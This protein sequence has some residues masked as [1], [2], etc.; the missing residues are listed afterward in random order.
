MGG[1]YKVLAGLSGVILA[2]YLAGGAAAQD[3]GQA[4]AK[5]ASSNPVGASDPKW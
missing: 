4:G 3:A 2:L 1:L 5:G